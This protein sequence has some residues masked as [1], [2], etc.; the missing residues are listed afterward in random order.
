MYETTGWNVRSRCGLALSGG[1]SR[2]AAFHCGTVLGLADLDALEDIDVVS[3]V[4]GGSVFAAAWMASKWKHQ[5]LATFID[6][7]QSQLRRGFVWRSLN[8][9]AVKLLL[10]SFNRSDLIADTFDRKLIHGMRLKDLPERPLLCMNTCVLNLGQVGK[11]SRHG[12]STINPDAS[13]TI[14]LPDYSVAQ[15][16]TASAAFPVGLPPVYLYRGLQVPK[17]WGGKELASHN[18]F[19][20]VDGG[21]LENL[22]VQTL[23]TAPLNSGSTGSPKES[24]FATWNVVVSDAGTKEEPWKARRFYDRACGALLGLLGLPIIT[25]VM[26]LMSCK[27]DRH[28]RFEVFANL[29]RSWMV[30]SIRGSAK[31]SA[32]DRFIFDQP[33]RPRRQILFVRLTQTL[34]ELIASVPRWRLEEL[35]T[36]AGRPLPPDVD[37]SIELLSELGVDLRPAIQIHT[38]LGGDER[39]K[40]LYGITTQFTAL[41]DAQ[42]KD[43]ASHARWQVHAMRAI[44]WD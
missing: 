27:Q 5:N 20:L 24:R 25:R 42:V 39:I 29:E 43:L 35:S 44:Y 14:D 19:A 12:F 26:L 8:W 16:A 41:S 33:A 30:E 15:A 32:L 6:E 13:R 34:V 10:P 11:F 2:A 31:T 37:S 1:G 36:Q 23:M 28:M 17:D 3:S 9:R 7:I 21:V 4:S 40:G 38:N 18:S 22:G